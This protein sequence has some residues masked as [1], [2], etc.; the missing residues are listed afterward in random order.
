[1]S[2]FRELVEKEMSY[3]NEVMGPQTPIVGAQ[4]G[5]PQPATQQ[6]TPKPPV[7]PSSTTVD[8]KI[9]VENLIKGLGQGFKAFHDAYMANPEVVKLIP[10]QAITQPPVI[11]KQ[12][13]NQQL[14][15]QQSTDQQI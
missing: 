4:T 7:G 13:T 11:E 10:K 8:P 1:M 15:S 14:T 12:P 2:K 3:I 6:S 9:A 5:N